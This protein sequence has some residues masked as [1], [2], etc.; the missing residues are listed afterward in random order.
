VLN[1][2]VANLARTGDETVTHPGTF[3][4]FTVLISLRDLLRNADGQ[5]D[6]EV[7][8]RIAGLLTDVADAHDGVLDGLREL[9]FR[10]ASMDVI[11]GRVESLQLTRAES[12]SR[13]QD[14]DIVEAILALQRQ[15]LSYQ[16]AL[17]V[18]SRMMQTS[19]S[20]LLR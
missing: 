1:V 16:A 5:P 17:Q 19:L 18:S 3:D 6:G 4:S 10:S 20:G 7:R 15:D 14:T 8:E 9:G 2:N 11:G 12:L 13:V